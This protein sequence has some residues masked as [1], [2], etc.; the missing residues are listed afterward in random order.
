MSHDSQAGHTIS[1][2]APQDVEQARAVML[3][4]VV[5]DFQSDYDPAVHADIDDL[6]GWYSTPEGPFMLVVK[7]DESGCVIATGGI[8]GGALKE[9]LSPQHLVERYR[10]GCTGQI[11][12]VYVLREERRRGIARAITQAILER[13]HAEGH[14]DR[15]AF[16]TFL[17]SPGAVAFWT[18]MGAALIEDDTEGISNA[19]FYEFGA[20][21]AEPVRTT[22]P[23]EAQASAAAN[24]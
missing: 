24:L 13:A 4:S 9:G 2:M 20:P 12:R 15:I 17:H 19:M 14:Y 11:V 10:D 21:P 1:D 5:E 18:S 3:R 7:D 6:V 8:R 22:R 16:H 23:V